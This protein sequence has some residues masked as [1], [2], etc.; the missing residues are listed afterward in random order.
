[1]RSRLIPSALLALVLPTAVAAQNGGRLDAEYTRLIRE[2]TSDAKFLPGSWA[3]IEDHPTVPSPREHF[4]TIIGAPGVMHRVADILGYYRALDAASP[5][6]ELRKL[7]TT[8]EGRDL[9]IIIIADDATMRELDRHQQNLARLADPRTTST[10]QAEALIA[11]TKPVYYLN[12][13]LHSPE[14]GSPEMLM[15]LAYRLAVSD[16][17]VIRNIRDRLIVIINPVA[18]PDGRDKQVDWYY[19]YTKARTEWED[20]FPRSVPYWGKY[21][22]HDN[23]RDGIQITQALTKAINQAYYD[24][25]PIVM[26]DLHES[27]PLLYISTGTG[28]YNETIDPITIGEW[29][30]LANHDLTTVTSEGLPG[31]F[32]WAF[33]DGWWPGY[34][35]WVANNHNGIGRFYETFGNAGAN[36]YIRDLAN[37]RYAGDLVTTPQWYRPWPATRKVRWSARD[38]V[39][40]MM[41]GVFASLDYVANNGV[42]LL[43]NFY[44]K[45]QN[46]IERGLR[47]KP[48][49]FVIPRYA[50]QRDPRRTAYLV[51]QLRRHAIEVHQRTS[52]DSAGDFVVLLNQPYRNHAVSLLTKQN[53]PSTAPNPP[54]DDIAWTLGYLYGVE[55]KPVND[56]AVF[57]WTGLRPVGDSVAAEAAVAAASGG[58]GGADYLLGYRAQAEVLPALYWLRQQ[59]AQTRAFALEQPLVAGR[60]T[61]PAGS[62]TFQN[63]PAGTAAELARRFGLRLS[64]PSPSPSPSAKRHALD[65]PR[66]AIYHTW[67]N[68]QDEGWV[69]YTFDQMGIP[70]TSIDKDDARRGNLRQ[71]FDVIVFPSSGGGPD[72]LVHELNR[73]W[74]PLPYTKTAEF[75]AHGTPDATADLTG[76]MGFAGLA[77]FQ[78]FVQQGGLLLL[79][80][81]STR[82]V[83]TG[84]VRDLQP[85]PLGTL[86]HPGSIV[87][88][89]ARRPDHP[90]M[91]GYPE[92]LHVFRGNGPLYSV[93]KRDRSMIVLQ[94]GTTALR[95]EQPEKDEGP[96]LGIPF[97][98]RPGAGEAAAPP[99]VATPAPTTPA[100]NPPASEYVLSGMVRN[101][102]V[103]VGQG[104]IF[105]VPLGQGHVVAFTFNP[106]HR[107]LNH[108]EFPM[109]WNA[110][111]HWNDF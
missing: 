63:L 71:R 6:V 82:L 88:A 45:G 40:Y 96:M 37:A 36:T 59:S 65:L 26:H 56:T 85:L 84:I 35:I 86:F 24:W 101:Q 99:A 41:T 97:Q 111:M 67:T 62:I 89:K 39:N 7:G 25:H 73:K 28:P 11:Q 57:R 17:P 51:N 44:R 22:Y 78:S 49:A 29:Q 105:D 109:V 93:N 48:H 80:K 18:E 47:E 8:E 94:Y 87:R 34:A 19:R 108:H 20:G 107:W 106:L 66:V 14:M 15:E 103:I 33:Y 83:E 69:R 52:G 95:D 79:M 9:S 32:T 110:L 91:Y 70:Y 90:I 60:D 42:L 30:V 58:G 10:A 16:Q 64:S 21:V 5:R 92:V 76:G 74:G 12:G 98:P 61:F 23:N 13:G 77:E 38:N 102:D 3:T 46:N 104:A 68:T 2:Y 100:A 72:G 31:A 75:A 27:V 81:E 55:V 53:F 43:R 4:G 50:Q 1:M 54:Y